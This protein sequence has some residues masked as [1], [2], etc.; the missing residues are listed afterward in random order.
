M[1]SSDALQFGLNHRMSSSD[2]TSD[3]G[4]KK[5]GVKEKTMAGINNDMHHLSNTAKNNAQE[6]GKN[7]SWTDM[8]QQL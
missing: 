7:R 8:N 6:S 4:K 3:R 2:V 5:H 1:S